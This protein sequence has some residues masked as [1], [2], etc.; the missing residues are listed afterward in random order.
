[1]NMFTILIVVMISQVYTHV[2][3][4]QIAHFIHVQ[5]IVYQFFFYK[6]VLKNRR[7]N[8]KTNNSV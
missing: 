8:K 3:I 4:Y 6:A 7:E 1:M 2:K 5:F